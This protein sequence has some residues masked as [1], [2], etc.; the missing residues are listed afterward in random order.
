MTDIDDKTAHQRGVESENIVRLALQYLCERG[1]IRAFRQTKRYSKADRRGVDFF[2]FFDEKPR[3][4][5]QVKSSM[6]ARE[7]HY[8]YSHGN[9][10]RV[11]C[12]VGRGCFMKLAGII[13]REIHDYFR[14]GDYGN[15]TR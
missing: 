11:P 15:A 9:E 12:V 3:M 13:R 8:H 6:K 14:G 7:I 1:F 4:P 5:L 10:R 2:I